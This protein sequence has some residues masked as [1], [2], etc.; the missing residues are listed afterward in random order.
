[1]GFCSACSHLNEFLPFQILQD[2]SGSFLGELKGKPIDWTFA[3]CGFIFDTTCDP[4]C[5]F[6]YFQIMTHKT[7]SW[8]LL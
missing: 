7:V 2:V 8:L 4:L 3:G 6:V 1:M 5:V